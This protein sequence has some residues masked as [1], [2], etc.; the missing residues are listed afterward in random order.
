[1]RLVRVDS[2]GEVFERGGGMLDERVLMFAKETVST[3]IEKAKKK[4]IDT[5][6]YLMV[7]I[8]STSPLHNIH[9]N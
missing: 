9:I 2:P 5:E 8:Y 6:N 1:M 7:L 3:T 4:W